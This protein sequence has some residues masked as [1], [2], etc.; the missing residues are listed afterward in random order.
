MPE[1]QQSY[2]NSTIKTLMTRRS[3]R[4]FSPEP[5]ED[6]TIVWL[7]RAAQQAPTSRYN[8]GWSAI[9]ITDPDL[10]QKLADIGKQKYIAQAPLLY[11]F[12]VDLHRNSRISQG[13][14]VSPAEAT[15]FHEQYSYNESH[16]DAVLALHAMETAAESL[17]LGTV[18]LGSLL[19]DMPRL[20]ELLHLPEL[21]FPVLG[22]A[23]GKPAQQPALKPRMDRSF[24]FFD[25]A[26]PEDGDNTN[27]AEALTD[28]DEKVHQY[29]DLRNAKKPVDRFTDQVAQKATDPLPAQRRFST[30]MRQQGFTA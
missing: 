27:L 25:N 6:D 14:G 5:I 30:L 1:N 23:I 2:P 10:A 4:R 29:Y 8:F 15:A 19:N 13:K 3:I 7:E 22:L 11:V 17:G 18:V 28:F 20:V 21:T 24:Q 26:Y 12:L 9:R 16:N